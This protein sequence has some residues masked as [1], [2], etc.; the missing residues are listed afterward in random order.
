MYPALLAG[1]AI[2]PSEHPLPFHLQQRRHKAVE[3]EI[4]VSSKRFHVIGSMKLICKV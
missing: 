3:E 4:S 1:D 2:G